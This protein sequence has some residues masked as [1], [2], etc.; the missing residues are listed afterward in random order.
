M[1]PVVPCGT[2]S[3]PLACF[4]VLHH[5][6]DPSPT[7][8]GNHWEPGSTD[9]IHTI[10]TSA[11]I[12]TEARGAGRVYVHRCGYG[13]DAPAI[14]CE[15]RV[16]SAVPLDFN[17]RKSDWM[18][19]FETVRTMRAV[20]SMTPARGTN[21]YTADAP[22]REEGVQPAPT[23]QRAE[24]AP[25]AAEGLRFR[26][27]GPQGG[28]RSAEP[29]ALGGNGHAKIYGR[30]DCSSALRALSVGDF[31][32]THRVF[33]AN[34]ACAKAAGYRPCGNCMKAE[35]T[36]WKAAQDGEPPKR[37]RAG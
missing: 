31:Y 24:P 12:A 17:K 34:E 23:T 8:W 32:K 6:K 35:Y 3:T 4:I 37:G 33:F 20:P 16:V 10:T 13:T 5:P 11:E 18:V 15:A 26:L 27:L 7:R 36:T 1:H 19:T 14:V 29:G 22:K 25:Q 28:Y 21:N 30:L 9:R 2:E